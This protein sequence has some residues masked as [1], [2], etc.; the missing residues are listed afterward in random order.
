MLKILACIDVLRILY[1]QYVVRNDGRRRRELHVRYQPS[2]IGPSLPYGK[3]WLVCIHRTL[4]L[5]R[6]Y[7]PYPFLYRAHHSR[8]QGKVGKD[9]SS[10]RNGNRFRVKLHKRKTAVHGGLFLFN[11]YLSPLYGLGLPLPKSLSISQSTKLLF[12][13]TFSIINVIVEVSTSDSYTDDKPSKE[14]LVHSLQP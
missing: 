12:A 9:G 3:I 5:P 11:Q 2:S 10:S 1:Q 14:S 4:R 7:L 6:P 8:N 13:V